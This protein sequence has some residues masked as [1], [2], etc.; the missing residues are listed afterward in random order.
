MTWAIAWI[1][2]W[3]LGLILYI[4]HLLLKACRT[5]Y[6]VVFVLLLMLTF[7]GVGIIKQASNSLQ[8]QW[9]EFYEEVQARHR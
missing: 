3:L 2:F 4:M 8:T 1:L 7:A 6:I 9:D 5:A